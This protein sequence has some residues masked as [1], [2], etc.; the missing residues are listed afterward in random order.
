MI[1]HVNALTA[2]LVINVI[3]DK[4][5]AHQIHVKV[6]HNVEDK[7]MIS[8]AHVHHIVKENCVNLNEVMPA[9]AILARMV[10]HAV[11][12]KMDHPFSACVDQDTEEINVKQLLIHVD[13]IHAC[14][15]DSV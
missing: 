10:D 11:K 13:Q 7:A 14:M 5:H 6:V 9:P 3:K 12:V 15:E 4:I 1:S 8:N 2:S